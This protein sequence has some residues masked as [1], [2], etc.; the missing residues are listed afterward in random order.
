MVKYEDT[1]YIISV[2][3][4]IFVLSMYIC[5]IIAEYLGKYKLL[6]WID[7]SKLNVRLLNTNP[8]AIDHLLEFDLI[9]W[10]FILGNPNGLF[11]F[12]DN[13]HRSTTHK[14]LSANYECVD[15]LISSGVELDIKALLHNANGFH[16]CEKYADSLTDK[17]WERVHCMKLLK[18]AKYKE[19][20]GKFK[21]TTLA[22]CDLT[23][24][25]I[26][27]NFNDITEIHKVHESVLKKYA[28]MIASFPGVTVKDKE[29]YI[30]D[31]YMK[32]IG[33]DNA[34]RYR[35]FMHYLEEDPS[36]INWH[37]LSGNANALKILEKNQDKIDYTILSMNHGI[38]KLEIDK[39]ILD[40]LSFLSL[41]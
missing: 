40:A 8:Y 7:K 32:Y 3:I 5:N 6:E 4:R 20:N 21:L 18:F 29:A 14:H 36:R 34:S 2:V 10:D 33:W 13:L 9:D 24:L 31:M 39:D 27:K 25:K 1:L 17:Q 38:F 37:S 30:P 15:F 26:E 11:I 19:K 22:D 16:L 12:K 23:N 28:N 35:C 41:P